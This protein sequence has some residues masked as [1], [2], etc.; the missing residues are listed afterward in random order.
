[1]ISAAILVKSHQLGMVAWRALLRG[2]AIDAGRIAVLLL[3]DSWGKSARTDC[4]NTES[5]DWKV[6]VEDCGA[7][8]V[9][10]FDQLEQIARLNQSLAVCEWKAEQC[11]QGPAYTQLSLSSLCLGFALGA[12]A[13]LALQATRL[14][15]AVSLPVTKGCPVAAGQAVTWA[16]EGLKRRE[17]S[18]TDDSDG[19]CIE[20]VARARE[21]ARSI[22]Q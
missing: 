9:R 1:M 10:V 6:L 12:L 15:A 3:G 19:G 22:Q 4:G 11:A 16:R 18:E 14:Q 8:R 2:I 5:T 20:E 13:I 7:A 17:I 21:R